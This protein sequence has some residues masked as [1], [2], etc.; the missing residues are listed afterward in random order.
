MLQWFVV[1]AGSLA[2]RDGVVL[3]RVGKA[4]RG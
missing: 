2:R 1:V 3:V 4:Y